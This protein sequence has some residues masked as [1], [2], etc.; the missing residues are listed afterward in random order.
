MTTLYD[1]DEQLMWLSEALE[2]SEGE[3]TPELD[4]WLERTNESLETKVDAY[5]ALIRELDARA[6]MRKNEA[7]RLNE[8]AKTDGNARDRLKG[9]L[10]DFFER[11]KMQ[12]LNTPRFA[13][14]VGNAGG[15]LP[16]VLMCDAQELPEEFQ[17]VEVKSDNEALRRALDD[18]EEL[19]FA[20]YGE[21]ARV[22]RIR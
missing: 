18:G 4:A 1:I 15:V 5:A 17:R 16:L 12:K 8:L 13:L 14:S 9:R 19:P 2:E 7:R 21:R 20:R 3:L 11:H 22:L 10:L 6:E